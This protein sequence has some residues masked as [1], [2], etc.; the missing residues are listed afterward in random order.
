MPPSILPKRLFIPTGGPCV[1]GGKPGVFK[2][3]GNSSRL[4]LPA[5]IGPVYT[6]SVFRSGCE[7]EL[8][9]GDSPIL[10]KYLRKLFALPVSP[11]CILSP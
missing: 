7:R 5:K 1:L 3:L 9:C 10:S 8:T 11:N 6:K 4:G 2:N